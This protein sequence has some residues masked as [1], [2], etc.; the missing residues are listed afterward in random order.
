MGGTPSQ[1]R[2][3]PHPR[4]PPTW[5]G[6]PP[7]DLAGVSPGKD[8]GPV[9]VLWDGDGVPLGKDVG[10]VEVLWDRDGV[11]PG[12]N[13]GPVEVLWDGGGVPPWVWTNKQ[14]ETITFLHPSDADGNNSTID[15]DI[16]NLH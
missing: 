1:D 16:C 9:E 7:P 14:T 15:F 8:M 5:L 2:V 3:V 4:V 10:L 13:V 12:K 6:Y 11:P